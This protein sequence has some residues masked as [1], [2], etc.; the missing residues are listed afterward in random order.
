V[1]SIRDAG[2]SQGNRYVP[3]AVPPPVV[4][5]VVAQAAMPEEG[6]GRVLAGQTVSA[7][8][9]QVDFALVPK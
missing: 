1:L 6:A 5:P 9:V 3:G 7:V 4:A 2:G 8:S